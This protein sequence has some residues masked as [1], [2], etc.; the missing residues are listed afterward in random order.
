MDTRK[1]LL[2][3]W[4]H[5][6]VARG[7]VAA[8]L[9]AV[10]VATAAAIGFSASGGG[11]TEGLGSLASGPE[12]APPAPDQTDSLDTAI[13]A[14]AASTGSAEAAAPLAGGGDSGTG[15]GPLAP[16]SETNTGTG[17]TSPAPPGGA[18]PIELPVLGGGQGGAGGASGTGGEVV[19]GV[20][21]TVNG[22][23][24]Q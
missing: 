19:G 4:Q 14:L 12:S 18:G 6:I 21:D 9:L 1:G 23:L 15:T 7:V 11:L 2:A 5:G 8:L 16:G 20:N 10:P 3:E 17:T 24:G 22:L 13:S